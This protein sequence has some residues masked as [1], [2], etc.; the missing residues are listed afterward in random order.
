MNDRLIFVISF[1]SIFIILETISGW[2]LSVNAQ[3]DSLK[4]YSSSGSKTTNTENSSSI[5]TP[6]N[7]GNEKNNSGASSIG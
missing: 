1:A 7:T 4:N 5:I 2:T 3:S 6:W